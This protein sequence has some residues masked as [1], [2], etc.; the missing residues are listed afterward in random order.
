MK[1]TTTSSKKPTKSPHYLCANQLALSLLKNLIDV[2]A[3]SPEWRSQL[4]DL[5]KTD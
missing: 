4:W 3:P 2:S 1:P 5:A